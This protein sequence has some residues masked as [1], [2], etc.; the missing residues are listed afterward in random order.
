MRASC[1]EWTSQALLPQ[2]C[3]PLLHSTRTPA[4]AIHRPTQPITKSMFH[5]TAG[6]VRAWRGPPRRFLGPPTPLSY[7][8]TNQMCGHTPQPIPPDPTPPIPPYCCC[9][10][11]IGRHPHTPV[12]LSVS[13]FHFL[14]VYFFFC[15][16]IS[17][18]VYYIC[19]SIYMYACMHVCLCRLW[20]CCVAL[21][22]A[23][24]ARCSCGPRMKPLIT[25]V[26]KG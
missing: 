10:G 9:A 16:F 8:F 3:L 11:E 25:D 24:P 17:L 23:L 13:L 26:C 22:P 20:R 12:C 19:L 14:S 21:L 7:H 6:T 1:E 4:N 18:S 2:S 5:N 15:L